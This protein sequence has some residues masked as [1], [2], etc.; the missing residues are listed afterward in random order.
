[1]ALTTRSVLYLPDGTPSEPWVDQVD[2][3][4]TGW[5]V[6]KIELPDWLS[7]EEYC[8]SYVKWK[9]FWGM[10]A[11]PEW[12]EKWQR[13]LARNGSPADRLACIQ[14][15]KTKKF[16]SQFRNGLHDQLVNWLNEE[17]YPSPFSPKQWNKL[18]NKY[19]GRRAAQL[20]ADLRRDKSYYGVP[21]SNLEVRILVENLASRA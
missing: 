2:L 8:T 15:L 12:P 13:L 20:E 6:H 11:D 1:M 21:K 9:H 10:G 5:E 19:V 14:L 18:V 7:T 4:T 3:S 17:R 16:R